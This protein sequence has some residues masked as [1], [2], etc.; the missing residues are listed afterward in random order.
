[1]SALFYYINPHEHVVSE[2][3]YYTDSSTYYMF[4]VSPCQSDSIFSVIRLFY[5][6][7]SHCV[8]SDRRRAFFAND[9]V[10]YT[11]L[12]LHTS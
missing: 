9:E 2:D 10:I 1:M 6:T 11:I 7:L 5:P 8:P 3:E 4:S 12:C